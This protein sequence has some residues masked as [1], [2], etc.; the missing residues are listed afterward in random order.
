VVQGVRVSKKPRHAHIE[1]SAII[2]SD[3]L[4]DAMDQVEVEATV[5]VPAFPDQRTR[6][7]KKA[8]AVT[9]TLDKAFNKKPSMAKESRIQ[10]PR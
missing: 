8:A 9:P 5:V 7:K 2:P 3:I 10:Q 1:T 6:S 4:G